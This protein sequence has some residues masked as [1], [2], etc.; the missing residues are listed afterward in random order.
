MNQKS[1]SIFVVTILVVAGV[2]AAAYFLLAD[3]TENRAIDVDLEIFGNANK[4]GKIS[5]DDANMIQQYIDAV[6]KKDTDTVKKLESTMSMR[7][8]DANLDGTIDAKDVQQVKDIVNNKAKNIWILDGNKAERKIGTDIEKIGCEYFS[9]TELC[10]IL[11]LNDKIAAVDNAPY[12]Y[13]DFYFTPKQQANVK[14]MENCN[15]PDYGMINGLDLDI[16]LMFSGTASYDVKQ[17]KIVDCDV[18]YL[19]LY[20]PD[21]TNTDKSNFVQGVLKAGYIFGKQDRAESYVNWLLDYRDGMLKAANSVT[22]K[23]VVAMSNYTGGQYFM[24]DNSK[25]ISL[26]KSND[27]LGQAITLAGGVNIIDKLG[28]GSFMSNGAYAVKVQID[29]VLNDDPKIHVDNFFLHM[30]KFTYGGTI[31]KGVPDHGYTTKD[32]ADLKTAHGIATDHSLLTDEKISLI[33]G[34]FRNG[35]TGGVLLAAYMGN[36]I[37]PDQYS[38]FNPVKMHNEYVKWMGISDYDVSKDGAFTYS[39]EK[40]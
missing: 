22:D 7:F 39:G 18:L 21:L 24:D 15:N 14:N 19:G 4:D 2:G 3:N 11:G 34:D 8:A 6:E 30:V 33:A 20:N 31:N 35:C 25:V 28:S 23:P 38:G 9:N 16:Y 10:L 5:I 40:I 36:I 12:Q 1:V 37:N 26:Y 29:T 27:P 32:Y 13:K 17:E